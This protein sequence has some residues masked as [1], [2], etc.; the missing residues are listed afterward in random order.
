MHKEKGHALDKMK[1][2]ESWAMCKKRK[3]SSC[4]ESSK[5]GAPMQVKANQAHHEEKRREEKGAMSRY[6]SKGLLR[7]RSK[8]WR[9]R[10]RKSKS[11]IVESHVEVA[12]SVSKQNSARKRRDGALG[13]VGLFVE[14]PSYFH[15]PIN[16]TLCLSFQF[17]Q[18]LRGQSEEGFRVSLGLGPPKRVWRT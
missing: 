6:M 2:K 13:I 16:S 1:R 17:V 18:N 8:G 7:Y 5:R 4:N 10:R 15:I 3:G 11:E 14:F 9:G 12:T